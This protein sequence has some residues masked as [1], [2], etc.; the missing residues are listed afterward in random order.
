[1][2]GFAGQIEAVKRNDARLGFPARPDSWSGNSRESKGA[3]EPDGAGNLE[4][5]KLETEN[6]N[7]KPAIR[8]PK[9]ETP[10]PQARRSPSGSAFRAG[11]V[12]RASGQPLGSACRCP[13]H[14][15][16]PPESL[17]EPSMNPS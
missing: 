6:R 15:K 3:V 5:R 8:N 1:V 9:P 14:P 12:M 4:T 13:I 11:Q 2:I 17:T 10:T 16:N 7:P